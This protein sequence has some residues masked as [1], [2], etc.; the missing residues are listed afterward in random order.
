MQIREWRPGVIQAVF[1]CS[2]ITEWERGTRHAPEYVVRL[3]AYYIEMK[4]YAQRMDTY[5]DDAH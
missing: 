5:K 4:K 3:L 1:L 2:N